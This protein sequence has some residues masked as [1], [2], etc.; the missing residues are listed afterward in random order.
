MPKAPFEIRYDP[1]VAR[2]VVAAGRRWTGLIRRTIEE[3][4]MHDPHVET[5]NR[6]PLRPPAALA[7]AGELRF[8]PGNRFRVFYRFDAGR[9]EVRILAV[10][11]KRGNHL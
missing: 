1:E 10:G 2:Q 4:L 6:K 3:R 9:R 8:G 7:E 11:V 5:T